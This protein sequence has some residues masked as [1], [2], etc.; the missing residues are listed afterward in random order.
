MTSLAH[1]QAC[2]AH[3]PVQRLVALPNQL[4]GGVLVAVLA[5]HQAVQREQSHLQLLRHGKPRRVVQRDRA[6]V[7]D[8]PVDEAQLPRLV[9]SEA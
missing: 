4:L 2:D 8:Q 6:A 7:G 5:V 1:A 3:L 9:V